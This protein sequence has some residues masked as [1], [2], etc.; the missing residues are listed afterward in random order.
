MSNIYIF[1]T[2]LVHLLDLSGVSQVFQEAQQLGFNYNLKFISDKSI[3]NS[4]SGLELS[5]LIHFS[6]TSPKKDDI[7]FIPGF[8]TQQPIDYSNHNLFFEWLK[9]ANSNQTTIC[10]IC[11]G[12]FLLAKSGLLDN[13]EC[14]TH[15]KFIDKLKKD[16]P[17]LKTQNN[18][19]F[20]KYKNIYTSAGIVTGIDLALFLIE[21]RHGKQNA[22][23]IAK[24]LVVYKRR[25]GNDEQESVYLQNRSH[26]DEKIH[27]I[28]DW[29]I[30]NLDKASKID[31]L[32]DLINVSPRNLTRVFKKQTG[33]TITEYRTKLRIEKAKSLLTNSEYKIE[34]IANLCGYKTSKQLR[35]ILERHLH[36]LPTEIK[37]KLS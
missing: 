5:S 18:T 19:L 29:I 32:A 4:S 11:T 15:W 23:Q 3:I 27:K 37:I 7:I 6:K 26:Q 28:Q 17:L 31:Y 35:M 36:A 12:A 34:H 25:N 13:K 2:N 14:T 20:T 9:N 1:I 21:E 16:F 8:N 24:E 22:T 30:H 33:V 10:S